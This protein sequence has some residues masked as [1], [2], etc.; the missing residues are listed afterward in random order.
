MIAELERDLAGYVREYAAG[1]AGALGDALA[2]VV[3][4]RV[5]RALVAG[6]AADEGRFAEVAGRSV[7]HPNGFAKI[8]LLVGEQFRLRL[9][10]WE[11][12]AA[13]GG[14]PQ[15]NIHNHAGPA[16]SR[17]APAASRSPWTAAARRTRGSG[18]RCP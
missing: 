11:A 17:P 15:E 16:M 13:A 6:I 7:R 4:P 10:T 1:R 8:V 14:A 5:F 3:R 9:H 18:N 2:E 12:G